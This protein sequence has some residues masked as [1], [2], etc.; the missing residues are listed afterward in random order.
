MK[1]SICLLVFLLIF[2][3]VVEANE[4]DALAGL[5]DVVGLDSDTN[6]QSYYIKNVKTGKYLDIQG[7]KGISGTNVINYGFVGGSNQ[8]WKLSRIS[9][10]TYKLIS[11]ISSS[12]LVLDVTSSNID[13]WNNISDAS[14]QKFTI[15]RN[16]DGTYYIKYGANYVVSNGSNVELSLGTIGAKWSFN[17]VIKKDADMF[18]FK[19]SGFNTTTSFDTFKSKFGLANYQTYSFTNQGA[20]LAYKYMQSDSVWVFAGHGVYINHNKKSVPMATIGFFDSNGEYHDDCYITAHSAI[21][22]RCPISILPYN[23]LSNA[24]CI[25]Y[26]GCGTGVSYTQNNVS[27]NLVDETY[28]KGAQFVLG[29]T[30]ITYTSDIRVW[31]ERFATKASQAN[32]SISDCLSYATYFIG[33]VAVYTKGDISCKIN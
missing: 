23:K 17:E 33:D 8:K 6:D 29:T 5:N 30:D 3:G 26:L 18:G 16:S 20:S 31:N 27:Y 14:Y 1:K 13:I 25:M 19:Y 32:A 10:S 24:K 9:G 11:K 12:N 4:L 15:S 21:D 22:N 7:G 28:K 2:I